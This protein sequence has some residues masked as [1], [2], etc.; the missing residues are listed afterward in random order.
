MKMHGRMRWL[1]PDEL[2]GEAKGLY[3]RIAKGPRS[4]EPTLPIEQRQRYLEL[5]HAFE[6]HAPEG[7]GMTLSDAVAIK[8]LCDL[9]FLHVVM[10]R[11][12]DE[13]AK[14]DGAASGSELNGGDD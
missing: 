11:K 6:Q 1:G 3:E 12:L 4:L 14:A 7:H 10:P 5:A 8:V 9:Y 13:M 2:A